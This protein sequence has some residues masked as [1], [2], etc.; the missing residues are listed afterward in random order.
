MFIKTIR[1]AHS[2]VQKALAS[3]INYPP[4]AFDNF[5]SIPPGQDTG[6]I[7]RYYTGIGGYRSTDDTYRRN[8]P[9][10][11]TLKG[12]PVESALLVLFLPESKVSGAA[13]SQIAA[14]THPDFRL[15]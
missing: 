3:S 12:Q 9:W 14:I 15:R 4:G 5:H 7:A 8:L 11:C 6:G 1:T 10:V 13:G 2:I